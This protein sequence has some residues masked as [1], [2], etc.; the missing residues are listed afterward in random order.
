MSFCWP[1]AF[2][3][4]KGEH[5]HGVSRLSGLCGS[6]EEPRGLGVSLQAA[7]RA[8]LGPCKSAQP[9]PLPFGRGSHLPGWFA[10]GSLVL[11]SV[12]AACGAQAAETAC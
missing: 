2:N 1:A 6:L 8:A 12:H 7:P 11:R 4:R 3:L 9:R 5:P 10:R